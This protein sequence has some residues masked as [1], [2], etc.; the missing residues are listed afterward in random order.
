M[1]TR[2]KFIG[3]RN[4]FGILIVP[5]YKR[6]G[7]PLEAHGARTP[8][9]YYLLQYGFIK[10]LKNTYSQFEWDVPW[11]DVLVAHPI[12]RAGRWVVFCRCGNAPS[13]DPE[14]HL[15]LCFECGAIHAAIPIRKDWKDVEQVLMHRPLLHQR[16]CN[17]ES[18]DELIKENIENGDPV[19]DTI[20]DVD[21][22]ISP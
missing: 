7:R 15:A 18:L 12:V 11:M 10:Q 22:S 13:V 6:I 8:Q 17:N 2:F 3:T 16:N 4:I 1:D 14:W 19:P 20:I 5:R 21:V 9:E